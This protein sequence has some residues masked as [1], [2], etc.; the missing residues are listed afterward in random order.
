MGGVLGRDPDDFRVSEVSLYEPSGAGDHLYVRVEKRSMTTPELASALARAAGVRERDVGHAGLKDKHAVTEQWFSLP[1][2]GREPEHWELPTGVRILATSRHKN[3]LRTGHLKG[4]HFAIRLTQVPEHGLSRAHAVLERLV[5]RG[6][7]NYFGEQRFGH[8]GRNVERALSWLG[9][10][11]GRNRKKERFYSKLYPS[12]IQSEVFNRYLTLRCARGLD[13]LLTGEVVRLHETGS[14]FVV[15][16]PEV[17]QPRLDARD[18]VLTGPIFGPKARAAAGAA[19]ELETEAMSG[20]GLGPDELGKLGRLA[21]GTR[22][23]LV[24]PVAEASVLSP[25]PG[26]LELAFYLPAGSYATQLIR[27]FTRAPWCEARSA[28]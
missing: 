10:E 26:V 7:Y 21:P 8:E 12:V 14:Y 5:T 18:L 19:L 20:L 9:A 22:R 23:D 1:A 2:G 24:V 28:E 17:E 4:N 11:R 15:E 25:H 6:L 27:E 13:R 16:R 3:K